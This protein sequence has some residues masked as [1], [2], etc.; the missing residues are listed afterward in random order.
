[1]RRI[2][3]IHIFFIFLAACSQSDQASVSPVASDMRSTLACDIAFSGFEQGPGYP[4]QIAFLQ[5][6]AKLNQTVSNLEQLGW[7]YSAYAKEK[8]SQEHHYLTAQIAECIADV[9]GAGPEAKLLQA[10]ALHQQHQFSESEEVARQLVSQRGLWFD[11]A[12][13]G[14]ALL[15]QGKLE[16]AEQAYQAMV[17]LKPG[18]EAYGRIGQLRWLKG[19]LEGAIEMYALA[20]RSTSPRDPGAS[21][22]WRTRLANVLWVN[23]QD[24]AATEVLADVLD[25]TDSYTPALHLYARILLANNQPQSAVE[26]LNRTIGLREEPEYLWTLWEV[27]NAT[28]KNN[29]ALKIQQRLVELGTQND[30]RTAS[31]FLSTIQENVRHAELLA[32]IETSKRRD[33]LTLDALA[34]ALLQL[35]QVEQADIILQE[36]LETG[37][38]DPRL[39][40]HATLIANK[41]GDVELARDWMQRTDAFRHLLMPSERKLLATLA[42]TLI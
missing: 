40:L 41:K 24:S 29:S 1:M 42:T 14:D 5:N 13:L 6:Q 28:G 33:A 35:N 17:D 7:A 12:V 26:I 22:F 9:H 38:Q 31:L 39:F 11:H 19:D 36:A 25:Q 37:L 15:E 30:P 21:A 16:A 34:F 8:E 32:R 23:R 2:I 4:A 3:G 10:H 20:A 27:L 18:P